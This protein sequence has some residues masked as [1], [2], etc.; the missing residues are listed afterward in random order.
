MVET[1]T[2][3]IRLYG[4]IHLLRLSLLNDVETYAHPSWSF[5]PQHASLYSLYYDCNPLR[6]DDP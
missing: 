6:V 2:F 5:G 3:F 1:Y 4:D